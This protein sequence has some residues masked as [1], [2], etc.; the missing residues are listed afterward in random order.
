[1]IRATATATLLILLLIGGLTGAVAGSDDGTVAINGFVKP[2]SGATVS[3]GFG[4]TAFAFEAVAPNCPGG[5]WHSGIDLAAA[6]GTPVRATAAGNVT[7]LLS[8]GGYGLHVV[9]DH[10]SGLTSLYGHLDSVAVHSGDVVAAD[11]VIGALG[12]TG[13]STGPHL[14]FEIQ[15]DG[16]AEDPRGD[17]ALP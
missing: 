16:I 2:V 13:N 10:G 17:L 4:C 6:L 14:H 8:V 15:R 5:H 3:Q 9:V 12:S 1:M 7:V 11:E